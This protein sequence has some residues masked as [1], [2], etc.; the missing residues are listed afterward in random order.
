MSTFGPYPARVDRVIDGDTA[1]LTID[2][3]FDH[4]VPGQDLDGKTRMACRVYG[5]NSPE[6]STDA[7]KAA[8][9]YAMTL[10]PVGTR[11]TVVS[12]GYDKYG[13]RWDGDIH[14]PDGSSFGQ[15]MI[16]AGFAVEYLP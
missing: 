1:L 10:L 5:I 2:L 6:L 14:L 8:R 4:F 16:D 12:H 7:G 15:R 11:C 9:D 3:G 13:G